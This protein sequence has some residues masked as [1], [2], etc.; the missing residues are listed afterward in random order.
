MEQ[1]E[2][3][4][5]IQQKQ[6]NQQRLNPP[7]MPP[8]PPSQLGGITPGGP[9]VDAKYG[10]KGSNYVP[11]NGPGNIGNTSGPV[12]PIKEEPN[13]SGV[14]LNIPTEESSY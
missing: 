8:Q 12:A 1:W 9:V 5:L 13:P 3:D 2:K 10:K 7:P 6:L 4:A 11:G 14:M